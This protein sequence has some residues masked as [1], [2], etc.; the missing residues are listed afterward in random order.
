[1]NPKIQAIAPWRPHLAQTPAPVSSFPFIA[2]TPLPSPGEGAW[3]HY[4]EYRLLGLSLGAAGGIVISGLFKLLFPGL[5]MT[6]QYGMYKAG[7]G[8]V[9]SLAVSS[10]PVPGRALDLLSIFGGYYVGSGMIDQVLPRKKG[11]PSAA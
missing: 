2:P 7:F 6:R 10:I 9:T 4:F 11:T 5:R 8:I 3:G 1:M